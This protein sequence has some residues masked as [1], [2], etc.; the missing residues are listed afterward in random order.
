MPGARL[1]D[2]TRLA[3][4]AGLLPTGVDRVELA[5]LRALTA[6]GGRPVFGLCRTAL[7]FVLLDRIGLLALGQAVATRDF[8][9]ADW[10]S[11]LNR[12]LTPAAR[13]GQSF[14]RRHA[15]ARS[16]R[17]R[18]PRL[19]ARVPA[20]FTYFNVGH[21]NLT[22]AVCRGI[23]ACDGARIAILIHDTIP[24]DW[25][26][27][28]RANTVAAFAAKLQVAQRHADRIIC[29]SAACAADVTRHMAGHGPVPPIVTAH[30]GLDLPRPAPEE[31]PPGV[32]PLRPYFV[33]LGT[34][35][36]R[37]NHALLLDVWDNWG[38]G[39][40]ALL[41]CG[42][43]GWRNTEVF[44]RLD[45][46]VPHVHEVTD[47]SDGAIAALLAGSRGLVFPSFA[48]G[49]GLPPLEAA[50]LGAPLICADLPAC[51]ELLGDWAVY[52][53]PKDQYRWKKEVERLADATSR[54]RR[55]AFVPP[56]WT[57]HFRAVLSDA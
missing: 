37:K 20:G 39:A 10:L 56:S 32:M 12:R 44:A 40:P 8:G 38:P 22:D 53:D 4:R 17:R 57:A 9:R 27:M 41:I 33:A 49:F 55:A 15:M 30:L 26:D 7:G 1:L 25:P 31:I 19:L 45:A 36:P 28:Q 52:V 16:T 21:S 6:D 24:L 54:D 48:E 2:V 35:E 14:V 3:S 23:R 29:T 43:R 18:L 46:G 11:R 51:R 42:R 13:L 34:I 5:Y 50:S 47:L